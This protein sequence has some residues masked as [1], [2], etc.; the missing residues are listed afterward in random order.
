[1]KLTTATVDHLDILRHEGLFPGCTRLDL[2]NRYIMCGACFAMVDDNGN[3][4]G[5]GGVFPLWPGVGIVWL[6]IKDE[7]RR[8]PK[9]VLVTVKS[10][11][12]AMQSAGSF[13]RFQM[14]VD[15]DTKRD[16]RFTE[17]LG[18]TFEGR[19]VKHTHDQKD[20]LLYSLTF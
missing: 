6:A 18:F 19:M 8:K 4:L 3:T 10:M 11:I 12:T 15:P 9:I 5:A 2:L 16:I 20:H 1:M 13:H 7:L 17:A 14:F